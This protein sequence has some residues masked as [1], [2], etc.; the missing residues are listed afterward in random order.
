MVLNFSKEEICVYLA[1]S[2]RR[3][4]HSYGVEFFGL[5]YN[6]D[7]LAHIRRH[8]EVNKRH[9]NANA[10]T[11]DPDYASSG[12][13]LK[14]DPLDLSVI[15]VL[16]PLS[17]TYIVVP[18]VM[19]DYAIGMSLRRHRLNLQ[20]ARQSV[21]DVVTEAELLRAHGE[22][23]ALIRSMSIHDA[24]RVGKSLA[25]AAIPTLPAASTNAATSSDQAL[26]APPALPLPPPDPS[27][28]APLLSD[29]SYNAD[30]MTAQQQTAPS[31]PA[32]NDS[33]IENLANSWTT[34]RELT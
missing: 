3:T 26:A 25:R 18:A 8:T 24:E 13:Y 7:E 11:S 23:T 9:V 22:V 19:E 34:L 30:N 20:Y 10:I 21:K 31:Q 16:D 4:I 1:R 6:C 32:S 14:Y 5:Y 28:R 29:P 15:W 33:D 12:N 17:R 2:T 27:P